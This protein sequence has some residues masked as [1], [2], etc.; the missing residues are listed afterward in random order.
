MIAWQH[1]TGFD[2]KTIH[3]GDLDNTLRI[4]WPLTHL[5][6]LEKVKPIKGRWLPANSWGW[7]EGIVSG[8]GPHTHTHTHTIERDTQS[9]HRMLTQQNRPSSFHPF[10]L[11]DTCMPTCMYVYACTHTHKSSL[12]AFLI[13]HPILL[14]PWNYA[15]QQPATWKKVQH[16]RNWIFDQNLP[17]KKLDG[18]LSEV[19]WW[20]MACLRLLGFTERLCLT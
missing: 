2:H 12:L 18:A 11:S 4:T 8:C 3:V 1:A 9:A 6:S 15:I 20:L 5:L 14:D 10:S 16:K 17:Q 19:F 7:E 13:L